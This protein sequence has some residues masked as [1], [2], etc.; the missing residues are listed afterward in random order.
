MIITI[1]NHSQ[2]IRLLT[3]IE[4]L[5]FYNF[6]TFSICLLYFSDIFSCYIFIIA[7]WE[8]TASLVSFRGVT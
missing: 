5:K 7:F 3:K 4:K 6:V 2:V 1:I 8:F